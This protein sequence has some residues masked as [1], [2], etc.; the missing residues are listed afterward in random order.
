MTLLELLLSSAVTALLSPPE[1]ES[2]HVTTEPSLRR[3]A[4]A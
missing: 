2:P 4:K 3:A 1:E